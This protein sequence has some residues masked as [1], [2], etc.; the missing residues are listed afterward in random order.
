MFLIIYFIEIWRL[1]SYSYSLKS[2]QNNI[3]LISLH[4]YFRVTGNIITAALKMHTTASIILMLCAVPCMGDNQAQIESSQSENTDASCE[5]DD[6]IAKVCLKCSSLPFYA[7]PSLATCCSERS[8]FLF[9]EACVNYQDSCETLMEEIRDADA[10]STEVNDEEDYYDDVDNDNDVT[11]ELETVV[12][13]VPLPLPLQVMP[14]MDKRFGKLFVNRHPKRFGR[15]FFGKRSEQGVD[16]P[17]EEMDKRFGRLYMGSGSYFGKRS[18]IDKRYGRLFTSSNS[19]FGKRAPK[20]ADTEVLAPTYEAED[21]DISNQF[22]SRDNLFEKRFGRLFFGKRSYDD[23][24]KRYGHL[25][26]GGN[27]YLKGRPTY[28]NID[29]RFGRLFTGRRNYYFGK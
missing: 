22:G 5:A 27:R 2:K 15:I 23:I 21:L 11:D 19:Y 6:R 7:V 12:E 18:D 4:F 17:S 13:P 24:D 10:F 20:L 14:S 8:A 26:L 16:D 28:Y 1:S 29:K 3:C 25:Y 9:C